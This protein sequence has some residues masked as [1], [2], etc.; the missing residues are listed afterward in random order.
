MRIF[1]DT[2]DDVRLARRCDLVA[3]S[4]PR[5]AQKP[6]SVSQKLWRLALL[7]SPGTAG[8]LLLKV[9]L[10]RATRSRVRHL[11]A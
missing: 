10:L 8:I 5:P 11:A 4:A 3:V 6:C 2:D 7:A 1:V 9:V